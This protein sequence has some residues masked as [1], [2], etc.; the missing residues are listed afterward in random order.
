MRECADTLTRIV[1]ILCRL[2]VQ[3]LLPAQFLRN[4]FSAFQFRLENFETALAVEKLV[5]VLVKLDQ[6]NTVVVEGRRRSIDVTFGTRV[7]QAP[8]LLRILRSIVLGSEVV[9][10]DSTRRLGLVRSNSIVAAGSNF[11]PF[12]IL[13]E[14]R[15]RNIKCEKLRQTIKYLMSSCTP[16][17]KWIAHVRESI[18]DKKYGSYFRTFF[19]SN[20]SQQQKIKLDSQLYK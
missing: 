5:L 12:R 18:Q 11:V 13:D 1:R 8:T 20:L 3:I 16:E 19:N 9:E 15:H 7:T 10:T 2:E 6:K 17:E 4:V 14:I